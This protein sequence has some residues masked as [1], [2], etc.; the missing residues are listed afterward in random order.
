MQKIDPALI[1][2]PANSDGKVL[3]VVGSALTYVTPSAGGG[4]SGTTYTAG[5]GIAISGSTIAI[6]AAKVARKDVAQT[7]LSRTTFDDGITTTHITTG[8]GESTLSL[9]G[10]SVTL[11]GYYGVSVES[12]CVFQSS[13][14]FYDTVNMN[15]DFFINGN[16]LRDLCESINSTVY[17]EQTISV[18]P[19]YQASTV[20]RLTSNSDITVTTPNYG[21][22]GLKYHF[23]QAGAG[24]VSFVAGAGH[25]IQSYLNYR[26][27]AGQYAMVTLM[28]VDTNVWQLLG[29]LVA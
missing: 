20:V 4:G 22:V 25:T 15:G 18:T 11:Y 7:F 3:T 5:T 13:T 16:E 14:T 6:D 17:N 23:I 2:V 24:R 9:G 8:D 27:I 26:K 12:D 21:E 19:N 28:K 10:G 1:A 29:P